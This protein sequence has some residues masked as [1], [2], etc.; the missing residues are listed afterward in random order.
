MVTMIHCR[1]KLRALQEKRRIPFPD[2]SR[3]GGK[4]QVWIFPLRD[5][6]W[7]TGKFALDSDHLF[8]CRSSRYMG[9]KGIT[10]STYLVIFFSLSKFQPSMNQFLL[11]CMSCYFDFFLQ[12]WPGQTVFPDFFHPNS[13][14]YWTKQ[15]A[16]FHRM[17]PFDGLWIVSTIITLRIRCGKRQDTISDKRGIRNTQLTRSH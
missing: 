9:E 10:Q 15:V 12:V 6:P 2:I 8:V 14:D 4:Y 5:S 1:A 7:S 16:A 13:Q 11:R 17:I 3:L